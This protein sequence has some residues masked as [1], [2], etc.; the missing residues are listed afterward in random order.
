M[1]NR[2]GPLPHLRIVGIGLIRI[3][4]GSG[5]LDS[6]LQGHAP[7]RFESEPPLS[8][9][10][11]FSGSMLPNIWANPHDRTIAN[12][13]VVGRSVGVLTLREGRRNFHE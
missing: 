10:Q 4:F 1:R 5:V 11:R 12:F 7:T 2:T 6:L 13:L 3:S 8:R 9:H